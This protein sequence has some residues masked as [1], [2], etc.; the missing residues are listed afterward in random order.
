MS[1][2]E[3]YVAWA[4]GETTPSSLTQSFLSSGS[5]WNVRVVYRCFTASQVPVK[6]AHLSHDST[7]LHDWTQSACLLSSVHSFLS[8]VV[9]QWRCYFAP[10]VEMIWSQ[11]NEV[12]WRGLPWDDSFSNS[13]SLSIIQEQIQLVCN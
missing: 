6:S 9:P 4:R 13:M 2:G 7:L 5:Y 8:S 11:T 3:I 1:L 12:D 10:S